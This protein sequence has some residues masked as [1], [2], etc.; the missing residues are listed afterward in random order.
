MNIA[1]IGGGSIG[2]NLAEY[3]SKSKHS[4]TVIERD[5]KLCENFN[6]KLDVFTITG[7]GTNPSILE[8]ANIHNAN[9]IIAVTQ[10]DDTNL[11]CCNFAKQYGV[12]KRIARL[13]STHYT[14]KGTKISLE[15]LGVTHVIEP[16]KE[17]V[18][19]ILQYIELPGATES[20]N[21]K[22]DNV[23]LRGYKITEDMPIANKS[24]P[25]ITELCGSVKLLIVLIV[26]NGKGIMPTGLERILPG[27]EIFVIMSSESLES[28]KTLINQN[29]EKP[30]TKIV[31]F[32]ASLMA[33]H[34]ARAVE[35]LADRVILVDPDEDHGIKAAS[36]LDNTEVLFGDCTNVEVLQEILV[37]D[38]AFFIA[39][40]K[41]SEDNIMACLLAKAEGTR[42]V[43]AVSQNERHIDLFTKLGVD[44]VINPKKITQQKIIEN[45]FRVPIGPLLTFKNV[46]IEVSRFIV[47]KNSR[48]IGVPLYDIQDFSRKS[49]ILGCVLHKDEVIIPSGKT[50]I[51]ENDEVIV[52]CRKEKLK[53]ASKFFKPDL[54]KQIL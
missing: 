54:I 3:L 42:E 13:K 38:A 10:N 44:H 14:Q 19:S 26:R 48:I 23:Y 22:S 1:I 40:D 27:D 52:I 21:F 2:F 8:K 53:L 7:S 18:N 37:E 32:G 30:P 39:A 6:N 35:P 15:E 29:E 17:I 41:D 20:A 4:I 46:D 16:E 24:L 45:I 43:I 9:M 49:I 11:L 47:Q 28:Y 51:E 50:I 12:K 33:L 5:S 36:M 31:I 34:L 25:K